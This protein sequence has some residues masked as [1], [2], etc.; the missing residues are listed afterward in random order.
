MTVYEQIKLMN[1]NQLADFL[2]KVAMSNH[3]DIFYWLAT[4]KSNKSVKDIH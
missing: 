4:I 3:I 1:E 2:N